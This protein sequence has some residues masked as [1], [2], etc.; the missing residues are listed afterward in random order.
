VRVFA[1]LL[2]RVEQF[3]LVESKPSGYL[4]SPFLASTT[5]K[6]SGRYT[7]DV[8]VCPKITLHLCICLYLSLCVP[9]YRVHGKY[10]YNYCHATLL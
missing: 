6:D 3:S 10:M 4:Q 8:C 7:M 2:S 5:N 9:I 1:D